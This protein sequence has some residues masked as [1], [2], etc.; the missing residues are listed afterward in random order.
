V[1]IILEQQYASQRGRFFQWFSV[2]NTSGLPALLALVAGFDTEQICND[3]LV[4]EATRILQ[5][6]RRRIVHNTASACDTFQASVGE[7]ALK[8]RDT[9]GNLLAEQGSFRTETELLRYGS[10][11][12][13]EF[14]RLLWLFPRSILKSKLVESAYWLHLNT[15][16]TSIT[17][18]L[19]HVQLIRWAEWGHGQMRTSSKDYYITIMHETV[20]V[21]VIRGRNTKTSSNARTSE[22]DEG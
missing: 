21:K 4:A 3:D 2:S 11:E 16:N 1:S 7:S 14:T 17:G 9:A 8:T 6:R 22:D 12:E 5:V 10:W 19:G 13:D 20:Q 18:V 15:H